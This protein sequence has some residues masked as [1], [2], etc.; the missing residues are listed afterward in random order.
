[1]PQT[2]ASKQPTIQK[3]AR[4]HAPKINQVLRAMSASI[5]GCHG[6]NWVTSCQKFPKVDCFIARH[7][8]NAL[9]IGLYALTLI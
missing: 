4:A 3:R 8:K 2:P 9:K 1:M 5:G 6:G 7:Q